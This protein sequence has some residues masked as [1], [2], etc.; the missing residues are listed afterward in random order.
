MLSE[1]AKGKRRASDTEDETELQHPFK[2]LI[3]RFTEGIPDLTLQVAEKDNIRD[4]KQKV[5]HLHYLL[6]FLLTRTASAFL[7]TGGETATAEPS[8]QAHPC[9]TTARRE[10]CTLHAAGVP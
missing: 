4:V 8:A 10:R 5:P 9:G 7:D 6:W 3:V 2:D 1:K